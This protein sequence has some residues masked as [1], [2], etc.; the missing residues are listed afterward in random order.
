MVVAGRG[1]RYCFSVD[2]N[3]PQQT[4]VGAL[5][6]KVMILGEQLM[7]GS[8]ELAIEK[9][10][11]LLSGW[12]DPLTDRFHSSLYQSLILLDC[13]AGQDRL[14]IRGEEQNL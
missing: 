6:N 14:H 3:N 10:V 8:V 4:I 7:D 5:K 1:L 11:I 13:R 12:K 2:R 9:N